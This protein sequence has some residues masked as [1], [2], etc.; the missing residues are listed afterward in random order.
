[1]ETRGF[2]TFM[3]TIQTEECKN[4]RLVFEETDSKRKFADTLNCA[5]QRGLDEMISR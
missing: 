2:L 5:I 4:C 1:M 3:L